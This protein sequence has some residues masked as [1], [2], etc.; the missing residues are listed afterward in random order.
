MKRL[1]AASIA[2]TALFLLPLSVS[3]T[4]TSVQVQ[5]ESVPLTDAAVSQ[6]CELKLALTVLDESAVQRWKEVLLEDLDCT[7]SL[8]VRVAEGIL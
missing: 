6:P 5:T 8:K 7:D 1:I 4:D 3:A 2:L